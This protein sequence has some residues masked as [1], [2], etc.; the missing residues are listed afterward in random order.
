MKPHL[1]VEIEGLGGIEVDQL[2]RHPV[3]VQS[4]HDG[5][6]HEGEDISWYPQQAKKPTM[7]AMIE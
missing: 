5:P 1:Q 7:T 6:L 4:V 3:A 2:L